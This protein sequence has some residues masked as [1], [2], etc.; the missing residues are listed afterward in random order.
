MFAELKPPRKA[1]EKLMHVSDAASECCSED[2]EGV[3]VRLQCKRCKHETDWLIF[4]TITEAKR[5]K[6]CPKCNATPNDRVEGRD[7]ALSPEGRART[8]GYASKDGKC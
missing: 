8:Q 2:G 1:P 4:A 3:M 5:G 6:P 7:A